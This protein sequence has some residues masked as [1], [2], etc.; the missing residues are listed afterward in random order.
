MQK[1]QKIDGKKFMST[2]L[3]LG[4]YRELYSYT[5]LNERRKKNNTTIMLVL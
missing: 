1:K 3:L 5:L 4:M 2:Q